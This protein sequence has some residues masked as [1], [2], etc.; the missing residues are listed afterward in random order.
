[1]KNFIKSI[2]CFLILSG[3][4]ARAQADPDLEITKNSSTAIGPA[5]IYTLDFFK[6]TQ[7]PTNLTAGPTPFVTASNPLSMTLSISNSPYATAVTAD[8][9]SQSAL[10]LAYSAGDPFSTVV[11]SSG[12][13]SVAAHYAYAG[14]ATAGTGINPNGS[15]GADIRNTGVP[16]YVSTSQFAYSP[17]Q[18]LTNASVYMGDVTVTFSRPVNNPILHFSGLGGGNGDQYYKTRFELIGST[19]SLSKVSGVAHFDVSSNVISNT[20]TDAL[21]THNG[22]GSVLVSGRSI[23]SVS[24]KIYITGNGMGGTDSGTGY[25]TYSSWS[26]GANDGKAGDQMQISASLGESDLSVTKT[27]NNATPIVGSNVIFTIAAANSGMSKSPETKVTDLLPS[28]FTYVSSTTSNGTYNNSTGIWDI[29]EMAIGASETMTITAKVNTTGY[30]TNTAI[31]SGHNTDNNFN[32]NIANVTV[33]PDSDGDLVP[34]ATDLDDDNDGILDTDEGLDCS[35]TILGTVFLNTEDKKIVSVNLDTNVSTVLCPTANTG[36]D[37]AVQGN[38]AYYAILGYGDGSIYKVDLTTCAETLVTN[39]IPVDPSTVMNALS[40]LPDGSLLVGINETG[41]V[42]KITD[43]STATPSVSLWATIPGFFSGGDFVYMDNF[44]Y[45][46]SSTGVGSSSYKLVKITV[47]ASYNYV[48]STDVGALL[49]GNNYALTKTASCDLIYGGNGTLYK[50]N[51]PAVN[52]V[53]QITLLGSSYGTN[54]NIYGIANINEDKAG[55]TPVCSSI[56]TDGDGIPNHLDLDSDND[57]CPDAL[58]G[59]STTITTANLVDSSMPG[60]NSGATSGTYNQPVIQNLGNTVGNTATTLGVP[61]I[62]GTGQTVGGSQVAGIASTIGTQPVAQTTT[63]GGYVSYSVVATGGSGTTSYQ[64]QES[65]DNG[66]TWTN[67]T[68]TGVYANT[69]T[70]TLNING[71]TLAMNGYDYRVLISQSDRECPVISNAAN[72]TVQASVPFTCSDARY[73]S[74]IISGDTST[75]LT[76]LNL[77]GSYTSIGTASGKTYNGIG[78]NVVDNFIYALIKPVSG[79]ANPT[80]LARIDANGVLYDMGPITGST[81]LG[82]TIV[83]ASGV[84]IG[85]T[86]ASGTMDNS[87]NL[88]IK[89]V[90]PTNVLYKIKV[91]DRTVTT[92]SLSANVTTNDLAFVPKNGTITDDFIYYQNAGFLGKINLTTGPGTVTTPINSTAHS[93]PTTFGAFYSDGL[94]NLYGNNNG[95]AGTPASGGFHQFDPVTGERLLIHNSDSNQSNDGT[96][97]PTAEFKYPADLSITKDDGITT[98]NA[99]TSTTYTIVVTNKSADY[100]VM[101]AKVTDLLPAGITAANITSI[102]YTPGAGTN[103]TAVTPATPS[104]H[105]INDLVDLP[106]GATFTY[107]VTIAIPA[108]F[109]GSLVNTAT[110]TAPNNVTDSITSN[111]SQTDTDATGACYKPAT[112]IG[113]TLPTNHGISALGRGGN[114]GDG[115][116]T[117]DWPMVRNG[118]WTVLEAKTKGFVIN[119]ISTTALVEAIANPVEGMMVY[120][121]QADCLKINTDGTV[122]GWKCFNTQTCP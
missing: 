67:L 105:I 85:P 100:G 37:I 95:T 115:V 120:D 66:T 13:G 121:E 11:M 17:N 53:S 19:V 96:M 118:A 30:Y 43:P 42:F 113:S 47:D 6:D 48:S 49:G 122:T 22:N 31:I 46:L 65:T 12:N 61:T 81:S 52:G 63:I 101:N 92:L 26:V 20:S 56:D 33:Q 64:W 50:I 119:R 98:Y 84:Y 86:G 45:G 90:G 24:F 7:N 111:N 58:E 78:Y 3:I 38:Y 97:C 88:Y 41:N 82:A 87:G 8:P 74:Q 14:Y 112:T 83:N 70:A 54:G 103:R 25:T 40:F 15:N 39:A 102:I 106:A 99:G 60:G 51:D 94:G 21:S 91:S 108:S 32:N 23:T 28:G 69:T 10:N 89:A 73:V 93:S 104:T 36:G 76:T 57:G 55:C 116:T 71:A 9:L 34:D 80:N 5:Q 68:N 18:K 29:G 44:L 75:T 72:L 79:A 114:D 27:V 107:D 117:N 59:G 1:M 62:A 16:L 110:V 109:A 77:D 35:G 2:S 4:Y